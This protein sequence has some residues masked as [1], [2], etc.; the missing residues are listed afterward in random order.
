MEMNKQQ[1]RVKK[2]EAKGYKFRLYPTE[3]Q[4]QWLAQQFGNRRVIYNKSVEVMRK[5]YMDTG[6]TLSH[7]DI[8]DKHIKP[9]LK[10]KEYHYLNLTPSVVIC[11]TTA[12]ARMSLDNFFKALKRGDKKAGK[13]RFVSKYDKKRFTGRWSTRKRAED[14]IKN[15]RIQIPK[16]GRGGQQIWIKIVHHQPIGGTF[17][18]YTITQNASGEY[19]ISI[20]ARDVE[21]HVIDTNTEID[22]SKN[23]GLDVGLSTLITT[24]DGEIIDV[25]RE[26]KLMEKK[27]KRAQ[28]HLSRKKGSKKGE[29]KSKNYLRQKQKVAKLHQKIKNKREYLQHQISKRIVDEND[30]IFAETLNVNGWQKN[31]KLSKST[32]DRAIGALLHKIEYKS[33]WNDKIFHKVDR[34][35]ASTQTCSGCGEKNPELKKGLQSLGVRK[36]VCGSCGTEHDRDHNAAINILNKG[37]EE[38]AGKM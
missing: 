10:T 13:P 22:G 18:K 1:G 37:M 20:Q 25:E 35:Y 33:E 6:K 3:E 36:W 8:R 29:S 2:L 26:Y 27:L 31:K 9:L 7:Y 4:K 15:N 38:L 32:T 30:I 23:I 28:K 34:F 19:Y 11:E 5:H 21:H 12:Q 17:Q 14:V 16:A 24:S